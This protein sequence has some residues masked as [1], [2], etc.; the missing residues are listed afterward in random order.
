MDTLKGDILIISRSFYPMNSPRSFRTTE[1]VKEFARQGH[2][3]TL[4]TYKNP[5]Y[6]V[7]FEEE[8]GVN[9]KDLGGPT[10]PKIETSNGNRI[11]I[12]MKRVLNRGLNLLFEYPDIEIMIRAKQALK[13]ESGYDLL[14]SIAV[15]HP[16][17]WGVA[18][19]RK[20]ENQIADTWVADCGDPYMG[21]RMDRFNKPFY[22]KYIEKFFCRKADA[23]TV[24][25][26]EAKNAYYKEFRNKIYVIPQGFNFDE[27]P[28]AEE[29]AANNN[30]IPV[31][32]YAGNLLGGGRNPYKL[33]EYLSGLDKP[34]KFIIYTQ[35][36]GPAEPYVEKSNGRIEIRNA[37]PRIELLKELSAMDFLVNLENET[38]MQLPSKLIDYYLVN[39]PVLS[40]GSDELDK[41]A[42]EQFLQEDYRA[43]YRF[44][45]VEQYRIENV[46]QQFLELCKSSKV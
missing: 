45:G 41:A 7:P 37:I 2:D 6:H 39:R 44:N 15:P 28:K 43:R 13:R 40:V 1:L 38:S 31:F 34:F 26:E 11:S 12:F 4:L 46:C 14:I 35:K 18:W 42:I 25:I 20:K 32:A 16:T 22:F 36:S 29:K 9:I 19:A 24:P 10:L 23:I 8:H 3:V 30:G 17:H 21:F 27:V 5:E 33:L